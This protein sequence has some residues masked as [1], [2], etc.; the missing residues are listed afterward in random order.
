MIYDVWYTGMMLTEGMGI[1]SMYN[2]IVSA[3]YEGSK[4]YYKQRNKT[5]TWLH[6]Q[7]AA[8]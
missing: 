3:L 5:H 7:E 8:K 1:C 6:G 4:P 2:D